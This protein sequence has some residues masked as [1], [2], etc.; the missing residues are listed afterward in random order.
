MQTGGKGTVEM[1]KYKE[2]L[3]DLSHLFAL[4]TELLICWGKG[5]SCPDGKNSAVSGQEE[6]KTL[7]LGGAGSHT[8]STG[9]V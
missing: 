5:K 6:E 9:L 8:E 7:L 2:L 4:K 1:K 3:Q